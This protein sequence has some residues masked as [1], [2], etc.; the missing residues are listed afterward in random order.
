M[1][2]CRCL[3]ALC[4]REGAGWTAPLPLPIAAAV[5]SELGQDTLKRTWGLCS[6]LQRSPWRNLLFL[7]W[8]PESFPLRPLGQPL[9]GS[10]EEKESTG[11]M[12]ARAIARVRFSLVNLG[13]WN[14]LRFHCVVSFCSRGQKLTSL[15]G[16]SCRSFWDGYYDLSYSSRYFFPLNF[17]ES[18]QWLFQ[19]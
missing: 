4:H 14:R 7:D 1:F 8:L 6:Q 16:V 9:W 12:I 11:L 15:E 3:V 17:Q 5:C 18:L 10:Y 13:V 19:T 2:L